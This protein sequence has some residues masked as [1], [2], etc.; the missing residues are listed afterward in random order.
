[1]TEVV[2]DTGP[3]LHLEEASLLDLL[4]LV[5]ETRIPNAVDAELCASLPSWATQRPPWITLQ[6]LAEPHVADALAWQQA[7]LLHAGEAEAIALTR[8][9][10]ASWLLTDDAAAR[11]FAEALGIEAHGSLAVVLLAAGTGAVSRA[12]ADAAITALAQSSLWVTP[13][14]VAAARAALARLS[15][16]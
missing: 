5:A 12:A 14:V 9:T 3:I 10:K 4:R 15:S 1:V 2:S 6:S 16:P 13:R 8:Q 11:L 7:G